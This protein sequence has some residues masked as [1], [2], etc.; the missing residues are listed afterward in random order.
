MT[1]QLENQSGNHSDSVS[2]QSRR[3][4]IVEEAK[5]HFRSLPEWRKEQ[6]KREAD[7]IRLGH[8]QTMKR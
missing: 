2:N 3:E 7:A 6:A 8:E 1:E 4:R 5:E